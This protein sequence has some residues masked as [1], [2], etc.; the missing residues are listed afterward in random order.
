MT[1]AVGSYKKPKNA[2]QFDKLLKAWQ[3]GEDVT[4]GDLMAA[5]VKAPTA[6]V[7]REMIVKIIQCLK[8]K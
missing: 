3:R 5:W 6:P 2:M 1:I 4:W 8:K 7:T